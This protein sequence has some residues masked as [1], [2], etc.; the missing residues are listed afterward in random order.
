MH[1]REPLGKVPHPLKLHGENVLI[2]N[3]SAMNYSISLTFCTEF[4][5]MTPEVL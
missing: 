1:P 3:N 4:N 5:H 2:V